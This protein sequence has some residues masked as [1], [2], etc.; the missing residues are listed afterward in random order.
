MTKV[1]D[2]KEDLLESLANL[3]MTLEVLELNEQ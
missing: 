2:E 3:K 1:H